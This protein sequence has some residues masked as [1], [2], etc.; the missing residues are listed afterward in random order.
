MKLHAFWCNLKSQGSYKKRK[1]FSMLQVRLNKECFKK[2]YKVAMRQISSGLIFTFT[3]FTWLK[4]HTLHGTVCGWP[5]LLPQYPRRTGMTD[6]FARMM[7]PRI[8]VA[9]SLEHFTPRPTW[10]LLSPIATKALKRVRWPALVCFCTGMILST[11]SFRADPRK[12]SIIS[13]S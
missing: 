12:K 3:H 11:S 9:T 1:A 10:P 8:A 5:I 7:A 6:N 2:V 13:C 4:W